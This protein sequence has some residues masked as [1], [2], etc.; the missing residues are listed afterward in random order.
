MKILKDDIICREC[1]AKWEEEEFDPSCSECN[2]TR[3]EW[4]FLDKFNES[5]DTEES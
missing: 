2:G 4:I 1:G 5:Q 3:T